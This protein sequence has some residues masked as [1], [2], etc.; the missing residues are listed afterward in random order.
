MATVLEAQMTT[1]C[2]SALS[3]SFVDFHSTHTANQ[4]RNQIFCGFVEGGIDQLAKKVPLKLDVRGMNHQRCLSQW[5]QLTD[6]VPS[7]D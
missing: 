6:T 2:Q 1:K 7:Y 5:V 4:K 3:P